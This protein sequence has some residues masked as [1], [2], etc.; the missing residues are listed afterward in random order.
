MMEAEVKIIACEFYLC[1]VSEWSRREICMP[2][3]LVC[4]FI[5]LKI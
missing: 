5:T 3:M 2:S 1:D 4:A